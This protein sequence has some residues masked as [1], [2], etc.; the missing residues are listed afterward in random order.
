MLTFQGIIAHLNAF[1]EKQGCII[2][3][4][5]D[6]EVGAGTFNPATFLRCL[7][8]E[9]YK[10]AY[11]EPSRRPSDARYGE[12]PNRVQLFHQ[13]QVI[14][15]PSPADIQHV[16]LESLKSLGLDLKKHDLRFVHDDWEGPTLGAWG[17]GWEVWCDGMEVT[18][19]TYFQAIGSLPLKPI[20]VEITYGLERLAM[21]IQNKQSIFDVQ[22]N[23]ELTF[24][25][26]SHRSEVE[27]S[28]YN[29]EQA[30]TE[31]WQRHFEDYEKEAKQ[32][33]GK[34]LPIPAYDFVLKASH[35][36]NMLDARGV[37]SVTERTGYIGR[38][39][40]LA[41][42]V[43]TEYVSSREKLGFPLLAAQKKTKA[44]KS[45]PFLKTPPKFSAEKKQNFLF[46]IGSEQLPAAFV[47]IGC[48]NLEKQMRKLLQEQEISF[49]DLKIFGTPQRLAVQITGLVEG[50]VSKDILKRGPAIDSAFHANGT[51]TAQGEG[52]FKS[53]GLAPTSLDS[54]RKGKLKNLTIDKIK[55]T[56]YLFVRITE[57]G[58]STFV[59]LAQGLPKLIDALE[60]P[61]KMRWGSLDIHY[62]RPIH[63]IAAL[64]GEKII[65][66]QYGDVLSNR[67][68]FGHAQLKPK[69]ITLKSAK[70]YVRELKKHCVLADIQER[71]NS[72]LKQIK[73]IEKKVKG[74][75]L[76]QER[77][78]AQVVHLT[79][80]PQLTSAVFDAAFLRAPKEVLISEMVEH[81]KYFPIADSKNHLKNIFIIT[82]DTTPNDMI[83]R[84]NQ[85]VLSARLTDGVFLY[86]QD[87]KMPLESFN[88]K[89]HAMTYQKE[90]GSM[91]DK[92][93]RLAGIAQI[94]NHHLAIADQK[95][96]QR[97]A[98]LSK[99]DLAS[100]LVKEF[101]E[102][103]G[104]IGKYYALAQKEDK[105]VAQ[106]IEEQWMPRFENAPLPQTPTGMILSLTDK[107]DNLI[108]CYSVGL[109]PSSSSDPYAL[110]RQ[111]IGMLKIL[112]E[113]KESIDLKKILEEA[114]G[115]FPKIAPNA[116]TALVQEILSFIT[117]RAKSVF[118]E[119]GFKK[120]ECEAAL[121]GVCIDPFDQF[122]KIQALH[123]F[124]KSP[125]FA[126][127]FEVYKRAK[128]QLEQP[129]TTPFNPNIAT[130]PAEHE[131]V[132]ALEALNKHWKVAL[133]DKNY[134]E[135][136]ALLAKLQL[137]LAKLFDTVKILAD[138]PALQA[139]RIALLQRVFAPF[140]DL[141]DFSKI[142]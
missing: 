26:V 53:L 35:A 18:Q 66:F 2:H 97:A 33:I 43:A 5:Y 121:Q 135:A 31:M 139:N 110:R 126:K 61:K 142:Q 74:T 48:Q 118:E 36:F 16:Y 114:C 79:E 111:V 108:G 34:N 116:S 59:I 136:F 1:W 76:C 120:D 125:Q 7:G 98:L 65:P 27:W 141:L 91:F 41:R 72:I 11:V 101:P 103:Q 88:E 54:I 49:D 134:T 129:T 80:W 81:Q 123:A 40:D 51:L 45:F 20:S 25:D 73:A 137:P 75:V 94:V 119:Y 68:S 37:I 131:L 22:W 13:Y 113:A 83:R 67:F 56:E 29:F 100:L 96:V 3:Q 60:F 12:N 46:E 64:L 24:R 71:K 62:A 122:R 124:R 84:G 14:I 78:L 55:E 115:K 8:P 39:R 69:K 38:I 130:E 90:L 21:F 104:T 138:D 89:L 112:I 117:A 42:L 92:V 50:T 86:E 95:K 57:P 6:L 9:P 44:P 19:F 4:G 77:V 15:K 133:K 70:D 52:F 85:K 127:L 109:K 87:L 128:G 106:A 107:I 99:A 93:M 28:A 17:L 47:P 140:Q 63:W 30:S 105:E 58:K 32:L 102:L 82:A 23:D 132:H 10:T